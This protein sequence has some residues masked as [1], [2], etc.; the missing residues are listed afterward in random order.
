M[1]LSSSVVLGL[2]GAATLLA[3]LRLFALRGILSGEEP[4][5]LTET[6][7]RA[8]LAFATHYF[9][10]VFLLCVSATTT[11]SSVLLAVHR[12]GTASIARLACFVGLAVAT[13]TVV[14]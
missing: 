3:V 11:D 12:D 14:G 9:F 8:V 7:S 10:A 1:A 5:A 13:L 2:A 6:G 4:L